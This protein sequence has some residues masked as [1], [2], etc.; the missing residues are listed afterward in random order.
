LIV[1]AFQVK[2]LQRWWEEKALNKRLKRMQEQESQSQEG[3]LKE[4]T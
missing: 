3:K 1:V 4:K 2:K